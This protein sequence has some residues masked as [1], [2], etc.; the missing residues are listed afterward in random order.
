MRFSNFQSICDHDDSVEIVRFVNFLHDQKSEFEARFSDFDKI[1]NVVWV[2]NNFFSLKPNGEW[3]NETAVVF[4]SNKTA[5]RIEIINFQEDNSDL[6]LN[7]CCGKRGLK[8]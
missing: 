7:F 2:L 8:Y 4:K 3:T 1:K 5:L 6:Y